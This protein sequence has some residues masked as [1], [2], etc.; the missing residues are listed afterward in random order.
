MLAAFILDN[1]RKDV[2]ET[3]EEFENMFS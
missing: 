1:C 2:P 3:D